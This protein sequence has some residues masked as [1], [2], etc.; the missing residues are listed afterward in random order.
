VRVLVDGMSARL[1]GGETLLLA[2]MEALSRIEDLQ[3]TIYASPRVAERLAVTCPGAAV[4]ARL[5]GSLAGRVLWEQVTLPRLARHHHVVYMPG[6]FALAACPRPQVVAFQNA[7]HFGPEGLRMGSPRQRVRIAVERIMARASMGRAAAAVVVSDSLRRAIEHDLGTLPNL[8]LVSG[9]PAITTLPAPEQRADLQGAAVRAPYALAIAHDYFHKDWDGLIETFLEHR[10]LPRLV[11]VGRC[12]SHRRLH[13]LL[14]RIADADGDER[15]TLTGVVTG[16]PV[17]T[18]YADASCYVAHSRLEAFPLTPR[19]AALHG[20]PVAAS[21]IPAHRE[22]EEVRV[23]FY[24]LGDPQTLAAAVRRAAA[25]GR[26]PSGGGQTRTWEDN[27]RELAEVMRA[28]AQGGRAGSASSSHGR[29][30]ERS[31]A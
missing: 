19:E 26:G 20:L 27:A 18:L 7:Y 8:R 17:R 21:D 2:Q 6:N 5:A 14:A 15:V 25:D 11:L 28:V 12:R 16:E 22:L 23:H 29:N 3:L 13:R 4:R 30:R 10:D 24:R 1:G 31:P 9:A